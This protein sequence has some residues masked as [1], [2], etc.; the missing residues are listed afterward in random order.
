MS[1][2]LRY[3]R[4]LFA[5]LL[6]DIIILAIFFSIPVGIQHFIDQ[7][8]PQR[9]L[10]ELYKLIM[11]L[12]VGIAI[13]VVCKGLNNRYEKQLSELAL[14]DIRMALFEKIR[15]LGVAHHESTLSGQTLGLFTND[16]NS[17]AHLYRVLL[18][19]AFRMLVAVGIAFTMAISINVWTIV[20]LIPSL[21]IYILVGVFFANKFAV[22]SLMANDNWRTVLQKV[23]D[24]LSG[25]HELKA[26]ARERWGLQ[27]NESAFRDFGKSSMREM[28]WGQSRGTVRKSLIHYGL[29]VMFII[30]ISMVKR[31]M[32]T[33]GAFVALVIYY[34]AL[35]ARVTILV[36]NL[37]EQRVTAI[38]MKRIYETML[39]KP[40]VEEPKFPTEEKPLTGNIE[41]RNLHFQ[42]QD[43]FPVVQGVD[44]SI[45]SGE[46][47]AFVGTSGSGKT[48]LA[49]LLG[50]FYDPSQGEIL[51]D[52]VP[53]REMSWK[54]LRKNV[55]YV[56]QETYLFG[57]TVMENIRFGNP[58]ASDEEVFHAAARANAH[59]FIQ[60]LPDGY[61]TFV[62]ERGVKLSGGQKQR[63]AIARLFLKNP[64][65][66]I[67]DEATSSLDSIN[68][69]EVKR[70]IDLVMHNRTII[71]IAHRLSTIRNFDRIL[72]LKEG[73]IAESGTYE[74]LMNKKGLFYKLQMSERDGENE[75]HHLGV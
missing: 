55:G 33:V 27:I 30:G 13:L 4:S 3:K 51:Y 2:L 62:G 40:L 37:T 41:I 73:K 22:T 52:G 25:A 31:E 47:V 45:R 12:F 66:V 10:N 44:I 1:F 38:R 59:E 26:S 48:T 53:I 71:V 11:I 43:H 7:I 57:T 49:K 74:Q 23:Y 6:T 72:F 56:F 34:D 29:F 61:H 39:R 14:R 32:I 15:K 58:E 21:V 68:E 70:A 54:Q 20:I 35:I 75:R 67:L 19:E 65:I 63:I 16:I 50:R 36:T 18:P 5:F 28:I 46:K 60:S 17:A 69:M 9:S 42:Y 24:V 8:L 64:K